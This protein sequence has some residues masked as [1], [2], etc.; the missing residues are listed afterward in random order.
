MGERVVL[1]LP[2]ELADRVR[3]VAAR[4]QR[5]FEDV[6][7]DWIHRG[8]AEPEVKAL[9]DDELL[10]LCDGEMAAD[11]Q[12]EL[13]ELLERNQEGLLGE[14]ERSR[15]DELMR[16]YRRGLVH[17]AQALHEATARG[18]RSRLG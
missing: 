8:G 12:E 1:D 11:Q 6:L 2:N 17:K 9:P 10:A 16:S 14:A 15:F 13:S 4:T 7:V 3:D 18:L 5:R